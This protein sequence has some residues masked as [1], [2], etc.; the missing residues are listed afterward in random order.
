MVATGQ[1]LPDE[2]Y[3]H[4]QRNVIF[5]FIGQKGVVQADI[6]H[7]WLEPGDHLLLCSDGLWEMVHI[8][9]QI[10]KIIEQA[11]NPKQACQDLI[12]AAN[13]AGG[14]D[15]IGVVVVNVN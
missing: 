7:L 10:T 14:E 6:F 13:E 11:T 9:Q 4:P 1:I 8:E 3:T 15:N 5:R 2:L 12:N